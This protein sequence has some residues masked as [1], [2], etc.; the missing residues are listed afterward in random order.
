MLNEK[1]L[2]A[3]TPS[4]RPRYRLSRKRFEIESLPLKRKAQHEFGEG[5][6]F[7]NEATKSAAQEW[8]NFLKVQ[9]EL[10]AADWEATCEKLA[11]NLGQEG[12]TKKSLA[13]GTEED[14]KVIYDT[15][16]YDMENTT[17]GTQL[18]LMRVLNNLRTGEE[19]IEC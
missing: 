16:V 7:C 3:G 11:F 17:L 18:A 15:A 4:E 6:E 1:V 19:K 13:S 10:S 8:F 12:L 9:P 5:F 14:V 2:S